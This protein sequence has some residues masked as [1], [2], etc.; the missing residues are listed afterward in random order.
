MKTLILYESKKNM[1]KKIAEMLNK[2]H[3]D[4]SLFKLSSFKGNLEDYDKIII[5]T[6]V[7]IGKINQLVKNFLDEFY[8]VI[9]NKNLKIFLCGMNHKALS[10]VLKLNFNETIIENAIIDYL[11][12]AYNFDKMNFIEKLI[13]KKIAKVK[14]SQEVIL[15][16]NFHKFVS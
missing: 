9:K 6:P 1:T 16:D 11:G 8:S 7:Y 10:D 14:E 3:E 13:V 5:G 4:S 15:S 2:M 12:G